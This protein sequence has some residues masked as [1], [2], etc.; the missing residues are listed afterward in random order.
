MAS[1]S[2][3]SPSVMSM[4]AGA[5]RKLKDIGWDYGV[6]PDPN[7]SDKV[8]C[9]TN[10]SPINEDE[11]HDISMKELNIFG[12][13]DNF[14]NKVNLEESLKKGKGKNV[15]LSNPIWKDRIWMVK[16]YISRWAYESAIPFHAFESDSFKMLLE[17]VGQ[18]GVRLPPPPRY[19][20]STTLLK[21]EVEGTKT[22]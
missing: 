13:I 6:C 14:A 16:K 18:F 3:S 10:E 11:L 12:L 9:D 17:V 7:V 1:G 21:E 5:K 15:N 4:F 19:E 22:W 2:A 20:M 8:K